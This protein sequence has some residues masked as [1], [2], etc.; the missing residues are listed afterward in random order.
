MKKLL[1]L[2]LVSFVAKAQSIQGTL[3]NSETKEPIP[4]A[5]IK[6]DELK[7]S[8]LSKSDGKFI[9]NETIENDVLLEIEAWGF[10]NKKISVS[11]L[12]KNNILN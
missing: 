7:K 8:E 2:L 6:I 10:E 3:I 1:F 9:F 4:Y 11:D 12:K 5:T